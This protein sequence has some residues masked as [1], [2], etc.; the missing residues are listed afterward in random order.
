MAN[1]VDPA[2]AGGAASGGATAHS[3]VASAE[4]GAGLGASA[5]YSEGAHGAVATTNVAHLG[6]HPPFHGRTVSWVAISIIMAGFL[7]GGLSLIFG[8][9]GPTWLVFWIGAGLAVLGLLVMIA[10]NT[11]EDWY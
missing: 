1:H 6:P 3:A 7:T 9:H 8:S 11:F 5:V 4:G 10:T 2:T